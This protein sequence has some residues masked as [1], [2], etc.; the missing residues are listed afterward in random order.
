MRKTR[1][2]GT[3]GVGLVTAAAATTFALAQS[4]EAETINACVSKGGDVRI[5]GPNAVCKAGERA[6]DWSV[7]GPQ[8]PAGAA[9]QPGASGQPG[10]AGVA[11][12]AGPAG[13]DGRDGAAGGGG[14]GIVV[15]RGIGTITIDGQIQGQIKGGQAG[16]TR[17]IEILSYSHS[18]VSPRDAASGLPTGK[19]Q[20][21]PLTII[22]EWDAASPKL[23][24]AL[25]RNEHLTQVLIALNRPG[26]DGYMLVKLTNASVSERSEESSASTDTMELEKISFTYQKIEVTFVDGGVT[27]EDDWQTPVS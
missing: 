10:A 12:P 19:R 20:H 4:G 24:G 7:R 2:F 14:G 17:A 9:G 13:R 11:G 25:V 16:A 8:G 15:P 3:L 6:V 23:F 26:S 21:K 1:L 22:K 27:H 5:V 18:I